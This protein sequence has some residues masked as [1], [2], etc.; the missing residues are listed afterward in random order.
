MSKWRHV[1]IDISIALLRPPIVVSTLRRRRRRRR[2]NFHEKNFYTRGQFSTDKRLIE[3]LFNGAI[4]WA[5]V[6]I[7]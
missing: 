5:I 2:T 4:G 3:L 7:C 6:Y 1:D